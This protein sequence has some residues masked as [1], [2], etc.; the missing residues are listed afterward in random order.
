MCADPRL[1]CAHS[2]GRIK[3]S[4][5]VL[6]DG[7]AGQC[8][9]YLLSREGYLSRA[10]FPHLVRLAQHGSVGLFCLMAAHG[11]PLELFS[12]LHPLSL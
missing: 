11:E 6:G 8:V 7:L 1:P 3:D 10:R 4:R 12:D 5:G 2:I 9:L